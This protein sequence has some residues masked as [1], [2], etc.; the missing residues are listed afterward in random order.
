MRSNC[1][2]KVFDHPVCIIGLGLIG[3]SLLRAL[4]AADVPTYGWNRS[5]KTVEAA[6]ADGFDVSADLPQV[7]QRAAQEDALIVLGVPVYAVAEVLAIIAEYA[8][9]CALTDVVSVKEQVQKLVTSAGLEKRFVG[10]HPMAG[11]EYSGWQSTFPELFQGAPWVV[12]TEGDPQVTEWVRGMALATGAHLVETDPVTHDGA[13]ACI[14]HVPHLVADALAV[15]AVDEE[16][17]GGDL[18]LQLA[19]GSF[20]DGTR[21]AGTSP[22][23]VRSMCEG[24]DRAVLPV[25]AKVIEELQECYRE[26]WAEGTVK[27]LT[28]RGLAAHEEYQAVKKRQA[29]R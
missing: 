7:L 2:P 8:P 26:L 13:V 15:A 24:N 5:L 28:S 21:V 19:A 16:V 25:L 1:Q 10:G 14:S 11:N 3:G 22:S 4:A 6:R 20:R 27:D 18:A 12:M 29:E 23:L 17:G 9:N